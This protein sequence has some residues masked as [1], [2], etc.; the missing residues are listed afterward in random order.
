MQKQ[1]ALLL[2]LLLLTGCARQTVP[3]EPAS[4]DVFAMDTYMNLKVWSADGEALLN[5]AADRIAELESIFSVTVPDSDISRINAAHGSAVTVSPETAEVLAKALEIGQESEGA[6]D[7]SVYP[8]TRA[9]GFTAD[10]QHVPDE[11]ELKE[12]LTHVDFSQIVLDGETVTVPDGMEIDIGA[13]A[14]GYTSD[15]LIGL[16]RESGASSAIVS[17]G[18]NVQALGTKPDGSK[19]K[20]GVVNPFSPQ[21]NMCILAIEDQAVITSGNYERYFIAE[22]GTRYHHIMDSS[23]GYPA[24]NGLVSVTVIGDSGLTCD[25][26]STALFVEGTERAVAHW[27]RDAAFEMILV[28]DD[29]RMLYTEGLG[30]C[31]Q[32]VSGM[33]AEVI[34]RE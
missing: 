18:G 16:F 26:L 27:R 28:T 20:V 22:D 2:P 8:V 25:A 9:W 12:L 33:Q 17:L 19:W 24:D 30:D 29:A 31:L 23:D 15:A 6:L 7:I 4:R 34:S 5:D 13:L 3:D 1:L 14:K 10:A 11:A 32:N 21:E